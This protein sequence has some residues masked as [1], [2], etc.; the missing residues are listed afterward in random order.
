M[1]GGRKH[2]HHDERVLHRGH[3]AHEPH[4]PAG[5]DRLG[6]VGEGGHRVRKEHDA[7]TR[8]GQV[9]VAIAEVGRLNVGLDQP[10]VGD[11]PCVDAPTG[12]A[13][14]AGREIDAD[15]LTGC[16]RCSETERGRAGPAADVE[17][18]VAGVGMEPLDH[19]VA[20]RCQRGVERTNVSYPGIANDVVPYRRLR[21]FGHG[22]SFVM[23]HRFSGRTVGLLSGVP[24]ADHHVS[25]S[26]LR[27]TIP[28]GRSPAAG[29]AR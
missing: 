1:S 11:V 29:R 12:L 24:A 14:H 2:R 3:E 22:A 21:I 26:N 20:E 23:S 16:N 19:R 6:D 4:P 25:G 13:E 7:A 27:P 28:C 10:D 5:F 18:P 9:E 15:D 8:E 17:D